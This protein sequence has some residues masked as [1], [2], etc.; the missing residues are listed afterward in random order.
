M[1][2][3]LG[4][5]FVHK[6]RHLHDTENKRDAIS[7]KKSASFHLLSS[8][9]AIFLI[10]FSC[11]W[12]PKWSSIHLESHQAGVFKVPLIAHHIFHTHE[13]SGVLINFSSLP[14]FYSRNGY[15]FRMCVCVCVCVESKIINTNHKRMQMHND[16]GDVNKQYKKLLK[17]Y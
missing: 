1:F 6:H 5:F 12:L 15:K 11:H 8:F 13:S 9:I 4:S 17:L 14:S 10:Y 16:E 7:T 2:Y 3:S